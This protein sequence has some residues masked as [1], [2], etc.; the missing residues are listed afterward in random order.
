MLLLAWRSL[1]TT[2][3]S[4]SFTKCRTKIR[5]FWQKKS[6]HR[7]LAP[8]LPQ[9]VPDNCCC[10]AQWWSDGR[11]YSFWRR[12]AGGPL[13]RPPPSLAPRR[14][15]KDRGSR[16]HASGCWRKFF[17]ALICWKWQDMSVASTISTTKARNSLQQRRGWREWEREREKERERER[18]R[19]WWWECKVC[20]CCLLLL[21]NP[22][23]YFRLSTRY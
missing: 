3:Q 5:F 19:E 9:T 7:S 4:R 23:I 2:V 11:H 20:F 12:A 16:T 13:K 15:D 14:G 8:I 10:A 21:C 22:V 1:P 18:E 17:M 6:F